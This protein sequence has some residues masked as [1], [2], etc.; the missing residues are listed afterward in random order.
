MFQDQRRG[1]ILS[2]HAVSLFRSGNFDEA[3]DIFIELDTNPAKVVSLYDNTIAGRLSTPRNEWI[4]SFGGPVKIQES[5]SA[6][7]SIEEGNR[8]DH[9]GSDVRIAEL[10]SSL[11]SRGS[12]RGKFI[13]LGGAKAVKDDDAMSISSKRKERPPGM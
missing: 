6:V 4:Q 8:E 10:I 12:I 3:M 7:S 2:L 13:G 9:T 11:P 5:E 1:K